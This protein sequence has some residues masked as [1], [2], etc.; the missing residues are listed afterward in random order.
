[1]GP[2]NACSYAD[3]A[4]E[5][6][7]TQADSVDHIDRTYWLRCRDDVIDIWILGVSKLLEFTD[8]INSLFPTTRF[9]VAYSESDLNALDLTLHLYSK[10]LISQRTSVLSQQIATYICHTRAVIR[11]IVRTLLHME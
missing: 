8:Y 5:E 10:C 3:L 1:M 6:V 4:V 2:K 9:E 11:R 7:D